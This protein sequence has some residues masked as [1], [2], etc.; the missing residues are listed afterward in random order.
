MMI[1]DV[2]SRQANSARGPFTIYE[3]Q[4][5]GT[6]YRARKPVYD[7]ALTLR[8]QTVYAETRLEKNG[9]WDNYYVDAI[10][11]PPDQQQLPDQPQQV[12]QAPQTQTQQQVAQAVQHYQE[13]QGQAQVQGYIPTDKD[14]I[15]WRQTA[16]KVAADLLGPSDGEDSFWANVEKL[17]WFYETGQHGFMDDP[18]FG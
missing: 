13:P 10:M 1:E 7:L 3:V 17:M 2:T 5:A 14:R 4:M 6:Q 15:I 12:N 8:G 9:Q 11:R 16:T 18:N